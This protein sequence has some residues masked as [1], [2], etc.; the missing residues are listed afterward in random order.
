MFD[1]FWQN[2]AG[3]PQFTGCVAPDQL[4]ER[5]FCSCFVPDLPGR[6]EVSPIDAADSTDDRA[7][8]RH[9]MTNGL[10]IANVARQSITPFV[11]QDVPPVLTA[12]LRTFSYCSFSPGGSAARG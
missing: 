7:I 4:S 2:S 10:S 5:D 12:D 8:V 11:P 1:I 6:T 9:T 3:V